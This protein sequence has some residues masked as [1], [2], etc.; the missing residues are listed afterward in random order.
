[1]TSHDRS[2][3]LAPDEFDRLLAAWFEADARTRE[4]ERLLTDTLARTARTRRIP[5]W[6]LPERWISM[7]L[8]ARF[9]PV[10]RMA[11]V[12][13]ILGLLVVLAMA[14]VY[15]GSRR[16]TLQPFGP[17]ANGR[18]AYITNGDLFTADVNGSNAVRLTDASAI[19]G[20]P[21]WA[22]VRTRIAFARYADKN[23]LP[24]LV[25]MDATGGT[26]VT[27][28]D[29]AAN[30][31]VPSWSPD[32]AILAFSYGESPRVY[33]APADG[34]SPPT[35]LDRLGVAEAPIWSPDGKRIAYTTPTSAGQAL[36]VANAD[37]SGDVALSGVYARIAH[38]FGHGAV[39]F[40]WSPDGTQILFSATED[41][42]FDLYV[43]PAD[44]STQPRRITDDARSEYG[45]SWSPDGTKISYL[46]GAASD[47]PQVMVANAD[48]TD[49]EAVIQ[50]LVMWFT[51][52]WS[53]DGTLLAVLPWAD[54]EGIWLLDVGKKAV[55][56]KV[57][58]APLWFEDEVPGAAETLT[59]ERVQ[60]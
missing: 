11:A 9:Q 2:S 33:V 31:S 23:A 20:K 37:G 46:A 40:A 50:Q 27:I 8:T 13:V 49:A 43:V 45:A 1:M 15:V 5:A 48:G 16:P 47:H 22:H 21:V 4:P 51:P 14:A 7:Q 3:D 57:A 30:L 32:D 29:R 59:F 18:V 56:S 60:P 34:S 25:T 24:S 28:V 42:A 17:A 12:M 39:G 52:Q 41:D 55:H 54:N 26:P 44:A 36:H 58:A 38:G 10:P 6:L 53:P 35:R 19:E